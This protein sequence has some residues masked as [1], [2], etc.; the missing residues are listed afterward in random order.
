MSEE[1]VVA[2]LGA[3]LKS[4]PSLNHEGRRTLTYTRW[5]LR[6]SYPMLWVH[7]EQGSVVE[8]YAKI[9]TDWGTDD[10]GVYG[11][12]SQLQFESTETFES[13]FPKVQLGS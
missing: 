5:R 2:I 1:D 13:I 12:S 6:P 10:E 8:V 11:L 4:G 9:Y 7:L 3:P